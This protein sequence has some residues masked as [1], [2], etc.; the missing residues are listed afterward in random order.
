MWF[1]LRYRITPLCR[2]R[3]NQYPSNSAETQEP[4]DHAAM[5]NPMRHARFQ[6]I[7]CRVNVIVFAIVI[8]DFRAFLWL[9]RQPN[10]S[11]L[12]I[13]SGRT[14]NFDHGENSRPRKRLTLAYAAIAT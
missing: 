7:A 14:C 11:W 5:Q 12:C 2:K 6:R 13:V 1:R 10:E 4:I 3:C 8:I 9:D